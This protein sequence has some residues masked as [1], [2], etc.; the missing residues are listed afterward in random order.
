M[1]VALLYEHPTWS[2]ELLSRL[3]ERGVDVT[4]ID[5]GVADARLP[6]GD[7]MPFDLWVNRVNMM[8]SAGR[9][10]SVVAA[11]SHL[12]LSL[13]MRGQRVI[14]GARTHLIGSSKLAQVELFGGLGLR[15]PATIG[16]SDPAQLMAA[17]GR[18]G[19][20]VLTKPNIGGSGQ[21]IARYDNAQ[22]LRAAVTANLVD[23]GIDGTGV[24]QKVIDSS[25]G[26][27]H[28]IEMLAG[29]LFY[30]TRQPIQDGVFNYCAADGCAVGGAGASIEVV[31]PDPEIVGRAAQIMEAA[32][33]DVGGVEY[34][35][36]VDTGQPCFYDFN[37]YSNFIT[38]HHQQLGFDPIDRYIDAVLADPA[39]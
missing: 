33:A 18:L 37:P 1:R 4:P 20:P 3:D 17:A 32:S 6:L 9:P 25:D 7:E 36:D 11:T 14:N 39:G 28:R 30:A 23:L 27:V 38:G 34:L 29:T 19:F 31:E 2:I 8:P 35:V 15:A 13:E 24:V 12:L 22:Q 10:R 5:V 21:G 16:V 26:L